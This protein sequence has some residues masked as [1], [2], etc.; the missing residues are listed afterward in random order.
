MTN[1]EDPI[2]ELT[3]ASEPEGKRRKQADVAADAVK[4]LGELWHDEE[5]DGWLSFKVG[6]HQEHWPLKSKAIR[7]L[8]AQT[9]YQ[10]AGTTL[11][12]QARQDALAQLE[13]WALYEGEHHN[14]YTRVAAM[15]GE[16]W[17]DLVDAEW[18]AVRITSSGWSVEAEPF[19]RF[20]RRRGMRPLPVPV[21]GGSVSEL[22]MFINVATDDD[23]RMVTAFMVAALRPTGPFPVLE[24]CGEAGS[25]KSTATRLIH[26]T[27]DP[28]SSPLR[29]EPRD[30]RDLM[31]AARNGW[32]IAL[33]NV[34]H[35]SIWLSDGICRLATGGGFATRELFSDDDEVIFEA[36]RPVLLNGIEAL[37]D[38]GDLADRSIVVSLH[39]IDDGKR[40]DE[41]AFWQEFEAARP[42]I[43]GA[44]YTAVSGALRRYPNVHLARL[45][46]MADF[47]K[48][49][50]AAAPDLGFSQQEFIDAYRSNRASANAVTIES[51]PIAAFIIE[52]ADRSDG[53][54]DTPTAL[55]K[56][57]NG[58]ADENTQRRRDWPKS[59]KALHNALIRLAPHLRALEHEDRPAGVEFDLEAHGTDR[60]HARLIAI[61]RS[62][63]EKPSDPSEASE[64]RVSDLSAASN[65]RT[66]VGR[67]GPS[68][69]GSTAHRTDR[70]TDTPGLRAPIRIHADASDGSD[71]STLSSAKT[72][73]Q[74]E[75][76]GE[77][78]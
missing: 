5:G 3:A 58:K 21:S 49:A 76:E 27:I 16:I 22:R 6:G 29:A 39:P 51:S 66:D 57:L 32:V 17:I 73:T 2:A 44:F 53:W 74:P 65:G 38:R 36:S 75:F 20:R 26:S 62:S 63:A 54:S 56:F 47:A 18:R 7:S 70:R 1:L 19:V 40:R 45:P 13:G 42:R 52:L 61:W 33:D 12:S 14:V 50:C 60:N 68:S 72:A 78:F 23:W 71:T 48:W 25:A 67:I 11:G 28:S 37:A 15:D 41:A 77:L 64:I 31:I 24:F 55:L 4:A 30:L 59:T 69:D 8:I 9:F 10:V 35:L 34:S 46:R 43:T